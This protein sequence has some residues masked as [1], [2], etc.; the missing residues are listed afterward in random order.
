MRVFIA[1]PL[2][3]ET[4]KLLTQSQLI[5]K[6]IIPAKINWINPE[7]FHI[8]LKFI[9]KIKIDQIYNLDKKL[10]MFK[11]TLVKRILYLNKTSLLPSINPKVLCVAINNN[12]LI[13]TMKKLDE[14]LNEFP[15]SNFFQPH[16]TLGRIKKKLTPKEIDLINDKQINLVEK[17]NSF[18]LYRSNLSSIGTFYQILKKYI[19]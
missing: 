1:I 12:Y 10:N 19:L 3:E 14:N 16:I 2:S 4:K 8:T 18:I 9:G 6:K 15:A 11:K 13:Q 5:Y 17:F 7:N